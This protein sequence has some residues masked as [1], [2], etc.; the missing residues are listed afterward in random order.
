M[1]A[2]RPLRFLP[3]LGLTLGGLVL[4]GTLLA[5]L[6]PATDTCL[7]DQLTPMMCLVGLPLAALL[8][9]GAAQWRT[10]AGKAM[11]LGT[12]LMLIPAPVLIFAKDFTIC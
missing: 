6:Y 7:K 10:A 9:L 5:L 11:L 8:T 1:T 12:L 3:A 4:Y 2:R